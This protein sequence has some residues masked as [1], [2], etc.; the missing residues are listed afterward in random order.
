MI[1]MSGSKDL[2]DFQ[3]LKEIAKGN[4]DYNS[5]ISSSG[6]EIIL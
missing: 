4:V 5:D 3:V 2:F 6:F 1:R